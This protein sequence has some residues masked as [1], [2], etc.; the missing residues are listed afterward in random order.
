[1]RSPRRTIEF[2]RV[3]CAILN[4][5]DADEPFLGPRVVVEQARAPAPMQARAPAPQ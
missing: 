3:G 2:I 5:T 4:A 1:M